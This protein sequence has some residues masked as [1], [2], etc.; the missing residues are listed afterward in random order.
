MVVRQNNDP[1]VL[2]YR[3]RWYVIVQ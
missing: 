2:S 3:L 1:L